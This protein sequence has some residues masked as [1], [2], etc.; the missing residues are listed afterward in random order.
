[1]GIDYSKWNSV[2]T[3]EKAEWNEELELILDFKNFLDDF[4]MQLKDGTI[5]KNLIEAENEYC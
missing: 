4:L 5:E 1:M 3:N 2:T